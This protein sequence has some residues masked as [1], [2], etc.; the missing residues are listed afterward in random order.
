[1]LQDRTACESKPSRFSRIS[2]SEGFKSDNSILRVTE[3]AKMVVLHWQ[4]LKL[5]TADFISS[6]QQEFCYRCYRVD[7]ALCATLF[8]MPVL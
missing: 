4:Y 7:M 6:F 2:T 1:M 5:T 3:L 8:K